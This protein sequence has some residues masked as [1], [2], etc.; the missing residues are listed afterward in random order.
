[1]AAVDAGP[2]PRH[3]RDAEIVKVP[4]LT[5]LEGCSARRDERRVASHTSE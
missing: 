3:V 5:V 1:M 4:F 2:R